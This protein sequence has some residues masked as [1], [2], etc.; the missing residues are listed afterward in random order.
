MELCRLVRERFLRDNNA[1]EVSVSVLS[2]QPWYTQPMQVLEDDESPMDWDFLHGAM[3]P[4]FV[5]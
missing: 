3:E 1:M 2:K 5:I 4:S